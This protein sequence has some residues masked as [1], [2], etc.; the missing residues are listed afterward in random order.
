[1]LRGTASYISPV[2]DFK[3]NALAKSRSDSGVEF[4]RP[5]YVFLEN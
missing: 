3:Y 2:Y 5:C 4:E 1:M